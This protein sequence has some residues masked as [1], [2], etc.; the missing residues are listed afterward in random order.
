MA[1]YCPRGCS[2]DAFQGSTCNKNGEGNVEMGGAF[3]PWRECQEPGLRFIKV[4]SEYFERQLK[5]GY[6]LLC[7]TGKSGV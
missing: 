5:I 3:I 6:D 2:S 4:I 1:E 7:M